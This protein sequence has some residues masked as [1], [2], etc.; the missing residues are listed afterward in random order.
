MWG[1]PG[2][3]W[4]TTVLIIVFCGAVRRFISTVKTVTMAE[5]LRIC[6]YQTAYEFSAITTVVRTCSPLCTQFLAVIVRSFYTEKYMSVVLLIGYY[7]YANYSLVLYICIKN[8]INVMTNYSLVV[9][10]P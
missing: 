3:E 4:F 9:L 2:A 1:S 6:R 5:K 8:N 10:R 7:I